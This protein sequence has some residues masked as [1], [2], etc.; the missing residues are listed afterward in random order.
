MLI[1]DFEMNVFIKLLEEYKFL[2]D[3]VFVVC[4]LLFFFLEF[5]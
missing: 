3:G 2:I 1:G 4:F 5:V